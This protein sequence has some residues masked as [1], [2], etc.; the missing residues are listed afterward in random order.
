MS[1]KYEM[2]M[3]TTEM[4][5]VRWAMGGEHVRTQEKLGDIGRGEGGTDSDS[6]ET[7]KAGMVRACQKKR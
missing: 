3:A 7:E 5:M 2:S 6:Y 1:I 4:R